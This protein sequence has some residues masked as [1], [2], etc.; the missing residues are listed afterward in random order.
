MVLVLIV[1]GFQISELGN[2]EDMAEESYDDYRIQVDF[3]KM[4]NGIFSL[5][6]GGESSSP[7]SPYPGIKTESYSPSRENP[8]F[9]PTAPTVPTFSTTDRSTRP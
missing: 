3:G 2:Y 1:I 4:A 7:S 9:A 6:G 5:F 8:P